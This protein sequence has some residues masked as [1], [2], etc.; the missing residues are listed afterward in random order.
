MQS[1]L[2]TLSGISFVENNPIDI[3]IVDDIPKFAAF[4]RE[5]RWAPNEFSLTV[6]EPILGEYE[7]ALLF[8]ET[9]ICAFGGN[10]RILMS[11]WRK[12]YSAILH[13]STSSRRC[14]STGSTRLR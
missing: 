3:V 11:L 5:H 4:G 6:Q 8:C 10:R 12:I 13:P 14:T 2:V 1:D 7:V 9:Y